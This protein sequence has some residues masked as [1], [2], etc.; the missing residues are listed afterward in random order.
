MTQYTRSIWWST[1]EIFKVFISRIVAEYRSKV[2]R[3]LK[4]FSGPSQTQRGPDSWETIGASLIV[5][6]VHE[7]P[8]NFAFTAVKK[9]GRSP[10]FHA[11]VNVD[12]NVESVSG[13]GSPGHEH[14]PYHTIPGFSGVTLHNKFIEPSTNGSRPVMPLLQLCS[15]LCGN[16]MRLS[17]NALIRKP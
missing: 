17:K 3:N 8:T 16:G 4:V 7:S 6:A 14:L 15:D 13:L 2:K 12:T 1:D 11:R 5:S 10:T 9:Q